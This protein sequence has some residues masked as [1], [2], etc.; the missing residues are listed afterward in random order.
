MLLLRFQAQ[1][2]T[3]YAHKGTQFDKPPVFEKAEIE[4]VMVGKVCE[5][6]ASGIQSPGGAPYNSPAVERRSRGTPGSVKKEN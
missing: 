4:G 5:P 2:M 6:Q 3:T 1:I